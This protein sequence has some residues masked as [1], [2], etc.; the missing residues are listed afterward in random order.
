MTRESMTSRFGIVG[1][2]AW[3]TALAQLL[4]AD[5]AP[6]RLWA[7]EAEVVAAIASTSASV[8]PASASVRS[9]MGASRSTCAR[10]AISGTTPP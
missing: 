10:A 2:G 1:G 3:G 5:G 8:F 4:A 9:T 7:R 6:V